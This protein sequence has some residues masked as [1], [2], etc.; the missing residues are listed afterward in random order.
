[1]REKVEVDVF[2]SSIN[3]EKRCSLLLFSFSPTRR[4]LTPIS[5]SSSVSSPKSVGSCCCCVAVSMSCVI[6][7]WCTIGVAI[8][9]YLSFDS[10]STARS[11]S[12][13]CTHECARTGRECDD[14]EDKL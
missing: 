6:C 7:V 9:N 2:S 8:V 12:P 13:R 11:T 1:M 4:S 14:V 10:K 3:L 5:S